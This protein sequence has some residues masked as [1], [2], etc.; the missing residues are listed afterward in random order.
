[1]LFS[2]LEAEDAQKMAEA[3]KALMASNVDRQAQRSADPAKETA[4]C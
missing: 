4:P 1:M 3:L 2:G